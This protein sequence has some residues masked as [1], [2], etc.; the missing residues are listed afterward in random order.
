S[1]VGSEAEGGAVTEIGGI[2]H[3]V[4]RVSDHERS[5]AWYTEVLGF[6]QTPG[7]VYPRFRHPGA[8]FAVILIPADAEPLPSSA[9]SSRVDHLAA[10][11]PSLEAPDPWRTTPPPR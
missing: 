6:E 8:S 2:D 1:L 11:A 7:V 3:V 9:P 5:S 4:I 10:S